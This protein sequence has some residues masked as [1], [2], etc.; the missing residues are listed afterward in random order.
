MIAKQN[1][2][3][4]RRNRFTKDSCQTSEWLQPTSNGLMEIIAYNK[5]VGRQELKRSG[6][7]HDTGTDECSALN[8]QAKP[9][10]IDWMKAGSLTL[11]NACASLCL[12]ISLGFTETIPHVSQIR[13]TP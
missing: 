8:S 13:T 2:M 10:A 4:P 6:K 11:E 9:L 7:N 3:I 5:G 1:S 12:I